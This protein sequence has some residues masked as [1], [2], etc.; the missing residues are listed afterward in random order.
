MWK[1]EPSTNGAYEKALS[2]LGEGSHTKGEF[3]TPGNLRIE[4]T[5]HGRL[6][7]GGRLVIAPSA[8][9]T[10]SVHAGQVHIAG[11][12]SGE[13]IVEETVEIA[14]TA[15]LKGELKARRMETQKGAS[16]EVRCWVGE[17]A[18]PSVTPTTEPQELTT[19]ADG[20]NR[21]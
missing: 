20:K 19:A 11:Q 14:S 10:G 3:S 6:R 5:F 8:E 18:F 7:V 13:L 1:K 15:K 4:G 21:R 12:F 9:I 16:L 2:L 17:E